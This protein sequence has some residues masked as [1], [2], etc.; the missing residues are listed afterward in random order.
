MPSCNSGSLTRSLTSPS[1]FHSDPSWR[2]CDSHVHPVIRPT[3]SERS[4]RRRFPTVL[5]CASTAACFI[6]RSPQKSLGPRPRCARV[7]LCGPHCSGGQ[8]STERADAEAPGVPECLA[9]KFQ[10]NPAP[11]LRKRIAQGKPGGKLHNAMCGDAPN[12]R[13]RTS[14]PGSASSR[15]RAVTHRRMKL[16]IPIILVLQRAGGH[17]DE[18]VALPGHRGCG[19]PGLGVGRDAGGQ[20]VRVAVSPAAVQGVPCRNSG[21]LDRS[22]HAFRPTALA[23]RRQA[24]YTRTWL[25]IELLLRRSAWL[26][27]SAPSPVP[28]SAREDIWPR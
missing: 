14:R 12:V 2:H 8:R 17:A 9:S 5:P 1:P 28:H 3:Y 13:I 26:V 10:G 24:G 25:I 18:Q 22:L 27:E 7:Q 6:V 19:H 23:C 16:S 20:Q 15:K 11:T 21:R 4:P